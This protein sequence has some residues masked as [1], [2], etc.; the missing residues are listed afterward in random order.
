LSKTTQQQ[1][2]EVGADLAVSV[3]S[4]AGV[5][6]A[7]IQ[8]KVFDPE[9]QALRCDSL[10]G[11]DKLWSQLVLMQKRNGDLSF[12]LVY[13]PAGLLDGD[14]HGYSTW[15]QGINGKGG[16]GA[17]SRFGIT[18]IAVSDLLDA[19]GNWRNSPPVLHDGGG[20]FKPRGITLSRLFVDMITCKRGKWRP[21][22]ADDA[23]F[24]AR[25][26]ESFPVHYRAY[27]EIGVSFGE[28]SQ[29]AWA[30]AMGGL[31]NWSEGAV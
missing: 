2:S 23:V 9:D 20:L 1:E 31:Q 10:A 27:R 30:D 26:G 13:V 6:R 17:S 12:L 19:N 25:E 14:E 24:H 22:A 3:T 11:W 29:G 16:R 8:A 5:K 28:A 4:P 18:L 15:E 7:L 21:Y